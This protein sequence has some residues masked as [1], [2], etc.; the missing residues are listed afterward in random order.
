MKSEQSIQNYKAKKKKNV[1][2]QSSPEF[3]NQMR[4]FFFSFFFFHDLLRSL[5]SR[6]ISIARLGAENWLG[7]RDELLSD[8]AGRDNLYF[9]F[10]Y[11]SGDC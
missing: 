2:S 3:Q 8:R 4:F 1:L 5:L 11:L 10:S 9:D 7:S 6:T